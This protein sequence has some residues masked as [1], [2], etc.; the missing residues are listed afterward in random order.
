[1]AATRDPDLHLIVDGVPTRPQ[2]TGGGVYMF[3]VRSG[4]GRV[5]IASRSVVPREIVGD[6]L[7]DPQRLGVP[8][9][10]IVLK[11]GVGP[12]IEIDP[13]HPGLTDGFHQD[14]GTHRWTNGRAVLPPQVLAGVAGDITVE[15]HIGTIDLEYPT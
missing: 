7:P 2:S 4:A 5:T 1:M 14:E 8:A 3:K 12:P 9:L 15:V 10:R 13:A 6:A 11:G